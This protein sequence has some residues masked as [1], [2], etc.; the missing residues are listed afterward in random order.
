[1]SLKLSLN[2]DYETFRVQ[3]ETN[4]IALSPNVSTISSIGVNYRFLF[5]TIG[6]APDFLPGN[7]DNEIKGK[8]ESL[9]LGLGMIFR[10]WFT[11]IK[12]TRVKGYYLENTS[13]YRLWEEGDPYIQFPDL[14]YH[15][16]SFATGWK[17]NPKVSL[18]SLI[19]QTER[20]LKSAGSF[21]PVLNVRNYVIDDQSASPGGATQKSVNLDWSIGAGYM[22]T[23]VIN[24]RFY[25][26]LTFIPNIGFIH[27]KLITRFPTGNV[28]SNQDNFAFRWDGKGAVG[29][30]GKKFFTGLYIGVSGISNKQ[31]NTTVVNYNTRLFYQL[32]AGMRFKYPKILDPSRK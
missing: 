4:T 7:G 23:F 5:L 2:T 21:M 8:T 12:Y 1:M 18:K 13:D 29:Y 24:E 28:E 27:T 25:T 6:F 16:I 20:Q 17:F 19:T 26:S 30:N 32:F 15:G 31:E 9:N 11:N 3:T 14:H 10:R 22:Y